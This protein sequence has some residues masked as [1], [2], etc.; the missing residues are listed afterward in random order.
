M[1]ASVGEVHASFEAHRKMICSP[2]RLV[3]GIKAQPERLQ[4]FNL[5]LLVIFRTLRCNDILHYGTAIAMK[6]VAPIAV[7]FPVML[8]Q[9]DPG[10]SPW[11]FCM[12]CHDDEIEDA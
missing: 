4:P 7:S 3:V 12:G 8:D 2:C 6:V 11:L 9:V 1:C 10:V 5:L